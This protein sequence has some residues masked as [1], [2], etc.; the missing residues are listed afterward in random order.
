MHENSSS[1]GLEKY[2]N[3]PGGNSPRPPIITWESQNMDF[4]SMDPL[5][6]PGPWTPSMDRVHGTSLHGPGP[7]TRD[8]S[9]ALCIYEWILTGIYFEYTRI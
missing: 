5:S 8:F 1:I 6:G 7:R 3:I 4:R 9:M 2:K